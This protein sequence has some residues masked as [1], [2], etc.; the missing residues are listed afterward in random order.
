MYSEIFIQQ[1]LVWQEDYRTMKSNYIRRS[2]TVLA[3]LVFAMCIVAVSAY[4]VHADNGYA[5]VRTDDGWSVYIKNPVYVGETSVSVFAFKLGDTTTSSENA[6]IKSIKSGNTSIAKISKKSGSFV[7]KVKKAGKVKITVN[8][9]TPDGTLKTVSKK[10]TVKKYPKPFKSIK[11]NGKSVKVSK[12]KY[13]YSGDVSDSATK[14][15]VKMALKSGWKVDTV[16]CSVIK[17][18]ITKDVT[19]SKSA[20]TKGKKIGFPEYYDNMSINIGLIKVS[21]GKT[22]ART[23]YNIWLYR[24]DIE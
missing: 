19:V 16:T 24:Q 14:A 22:V 23:S 15:S 8:F 2:L 11:I 4:N 17:G 13:K 18:S 6:T 12:N 7:W 20:V 1:E 21:G 3:A 5:N 10:I 9:T